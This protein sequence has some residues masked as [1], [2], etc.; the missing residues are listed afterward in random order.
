MSHPLDP[1][2]NPRVIAV[3]GASNDPEKRGY[4]A[5][6][7]L[8]SDNYQGKIIPIN[9]KSAEILGLKCYPSI[10]DVTDA[11][12]LAL[13]CTAAR[14]VPEVVRSCGKQGVKGALLLAGGFSEAS[15]E[16]RVLEEA[17]VAIAREYGIRLIGPNT[18]GMFSARFG[19]NAIG[20]Y[21]LPRGPLAMIANSANV[22]LSVVTEAQFHRHFG[23]STLLPL[24]NQADIQFHECLDALSQDP[25]TKAVISYVEGFRNGR[26]FYEV[27]RRVSPHKPIVMFK[28]GRTADGVN[29]ARS[30]S[31]SLAGDYAVATGVIKQAGI[32]LVERADCLFPVAEALALLPPMP[33]RRV[34]ILSE[35]GG[36]ITVAAEALAERGMVLAKLTAET[37]AKLK[38]IVPAASA[39]S[40]PVDHGG[41]TDPRAEYYGQCG[42]A[43]LEDPNVD[44]LLCVG[45]LGGYAHRYGDS[46]GE[47]ENS[48][49]KGFGDLMRKH[50][51]AIVVQ[52]HYAHFR[53]PALDILRN[54]GVPFYRSIEIAAHC[55]ASLAD[56][57]A[58]RRRL[59]SD[60]QD[61]G[62]TPAVVP[63]VQ[64]MLAD[65][66]AAQRMALLEP[67]AREV[68]RAA[69]IAMPP[70]LLLKS[71][72]DA[73]AAVKSLGAGAL[74]LKVVSKDV[75]HKSDTGGVVL[76]AA[77]AAAIREGYAR[78]MQSVQAKVPGAVI[79]GVLASPMAPAGVELIVGV[80]RD[81]QFGPVIMFGLGGVFVET[82]RDVVFRAVPISRADAGEMIA[83]IRFKGM[84]EGARGLP[85]VNTTA[86]IE[87]LL[88]VSALAAA[89]P[90]LAEID[91]NPVIAHGDTWSI[92][93]ARMILG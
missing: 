4:R 72:A 88:K 18:N 14:T 55:L 61:A 41:G 29:A 70:S 62:A 91:L 77:G 17:A 73:D 9:P 85:K 51:K 11:V 25:D 30:H 2:F 6:K 76:N 12:D 93:D 50:Q 46:V 78:I 5:I 87:L 8:L 45:F 67:E 68:L 1:V 48:V 28:A 34:A 15:E 33:T 39:L 13:V 75:L 19:C 79:D 66:R 36:V 82:I 63:A 37:Q 22:M 60:A 27:A 47:M 56:Y 59:A 53:T 64:K 74:A 40:N 24:G 83:D 65:A 44:A 57:S 84:L 81:P 69:G 26:A 42:K 86:L 20:W 43:I 38:A 16:G 10:A 71:A 54:A 52:S 35:G 58:M 32:P 90:D 21:D 3:I 89:H 92:V 7:T 80:T 49:C 31:G 23:F